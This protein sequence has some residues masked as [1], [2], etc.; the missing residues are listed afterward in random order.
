MDEERS[1]AFEVKA[2]CAQE[3]LGANVSAWRE[4]TTNGQMVPW[5]DAGSSLSGAEE[6]TRN[7]GC[8]GTVLSCIEATKAI[9][10]HRVQRTGCWHFHLKSQIS[11]P[12]V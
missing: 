7:D 8:D 9:T 6:E 4:R 1:E 2:M 3:V 11:V 12:K 10:R 5:T